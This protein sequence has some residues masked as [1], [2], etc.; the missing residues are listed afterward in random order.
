[1]K[2]LVTFAVEAEFSAWRAR[3]KFQQLELGVAE[4]GTKVHVYEARIGDEES[5]STNK[6][7]VFLTGV[8]WG[9]VKFAFRKVMS[10]W[11]TY[12]ISSGLSG[13]LKE[14]YRSGDV[15]VA[16]GAQLLGTNLRIE[17][18]RPLVRAAMACGARLCQSSLTV[19]SILALSSQKRAAGEHGDIVDMESYHVLTAASGKKIPASVVIRSI[20][21]TVEENIPL[22]FTR[23][24]DARGGLKL[25]SLLGEIGRRPQKI[26]A[27]IRFGRR[28]RSATNSLADFLDR[29][30]P[31]IQHGTEAWSNE[32]FEQVAAQ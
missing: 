10:G 26:P 28:S 30:I 8:G 29:Y 32:H 23:V 14:S 7:W 25:G 12:C 11:P 1:M 17:G 13:G 4:D 31:T 5:I 24:A 21:D 6:V 2:V 20:S 15:V 16:Q 19:D 9:N 22:D 27:L 3:H 18:H